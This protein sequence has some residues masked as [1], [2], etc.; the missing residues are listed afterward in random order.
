MVSDTYYPYVGG[1]PEHIFNLS[2]QLRIR[3]HTV[4]ILTT[5]F[6]RRLFYLDSPIPDEEYVYR[7]GRGLLI[8]ANKSFAQIPIGWRLSDKIEKFFRKENFD[9]VHIHGSLAP[10][11][12]ILAL[13]HSRAINLITYHAEHPKDYKYLLAYEVLLPY[14]RKL[15][16]RIAVS[17]PAY[18]SNMHMYSRADCRIIPN[19][20]DTNTFN[21]NVQPLPIYQDN[22]PKI[23]FLGRIEPRKGLKYL[24]LAFRNVV[25]KFPNALLIIVGK[26][27]LGYSYQQY[28]TSEIKNN[29][30]FVGLIPNHIK[31][32]YYASCDVFCAPSVGRES[33]GIILLEA[34]ATGKPVVA[35]NIS[36]YRTII[37]DGV[38]GYLAQPKDPEDIAT[39]IIKILEDAALRKELG[40][41][42]RAKALR[43]SWEKVSAQV[44]EYYYELIAR[45]KRNI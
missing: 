42:A 37:E 12:P 30:H 33:F 36:G 34:M 1:I 11:L 25:K 32:Q 10:T 2:R 16:G 22:R 40:T 28:I 21:P 27:L 24:L 44:E 17:E 7:I 5:N 38:D 20:V 26:G 19:G 31:P 4:K 9:I 15:Q 45:Y 8:S 6:S 23:L 18:I 3:G 35:S 29:I 39:K 13:R 41:R 43:Y 14:Q